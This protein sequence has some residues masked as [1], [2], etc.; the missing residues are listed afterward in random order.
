MGLIKLVDSD[1]DVARL[2]DEVFALITE[3]N[4]SERQQI[5]LTSLDGSNDW[6]AGSGKIRDLPHPEERYN[7]VNAALQQL[8]IAELIQRYSRFYRWRLLKLAP[9]QSYSVHRDGIDR[10]NYRLH[11]PVVTNSESLFSFYSTRPGDKVR[12]NVYFEHLALG[13]SYEVNTSNFHT[14]VNYGNTDRYH[15]VGVRYEDINNRAH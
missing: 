3:H 11:I 1:I 6:D 10:V 7:I 5:S 9:K 4:L 13:N 8:Y 14:A 15:I 12:A 2:S